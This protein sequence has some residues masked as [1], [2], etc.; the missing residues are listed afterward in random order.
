MPRALSDRDA[1]RVVIA[2]GQHEV[3]VLPRGEVHA[4]ELGAHRRVHPRL[5]ERGA[6]GGFDGG[7]VLPRG[8][9]R[10]R[11]GLRP[12]EHA[13]HVG[14]DAVAHPQLYLLVGGAVRIREDM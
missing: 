12:G 8:L 6:G 5:V 2:G 4:A 3:V 10:V 11:L 1:H 14:E 9:L 13:A 7:Q